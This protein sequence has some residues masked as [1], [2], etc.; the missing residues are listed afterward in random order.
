MPPKLR[1]DGVGTTSTTDDANS[2]AGDDNDSETSNATAGQ[3]VQQLLEF[4]KEQEAERNRMMRELMDTK[5]KTNESPIPRTLL[6]DRSK[7]VQVFNGEGDERHAEEWLDTFNELSL[8]CKW[9]DD[10]KLTLVQAK[11]VGPAS[12]W[13]R[14]KVKDCPTWELFELN[15]RKMFAPT[16]DP[17]NKFDEMRRRVQGKDE[18]ILA[19][20]MDKMHLCKRCGL[21]DIQSKEQILL[22]VIDRTT[23]Q[24]LMPKQYACLEDLLRDLRRSDGL[25]R[26]RR[27]HFGGSKQASTSDSKTAKATTSQQK[28]AHQKGGMWAPA[29]D[30]QGR[31]KC[32][33]CNE[34]ANHL[35]ADC[36]K[37]KRTKFCTKCMQSGHGKRD[38]KSKPQDAHPRR[39]DTL[40]VGDI[41]KYTKNV[42]INGSVDATS[43][44]DQG[45]AVTIMTASTAVRSGCVVHPATEDDAL[46]GLG[47]KKTVP[48][49][50]TR[51]TLEIDGI[52]A[53][54]EI[55]VVSDDVICHDVLVGRT[56][57][58]LDNVVMIK[59]KDQMRLIDSS[60]EGPFKNFTLDDGEFKCTLRSTETVTVPPKTVQF[61]NV[62]SGDTDET[63]LIMFPHYGDGLSCLLEVRKGHTMVPVINDSHEPLII[64]KD[65]SFG[66]AEPVEICAQ[67]ETIPTDDDR[68]MQQS[69]PKESTCDVLSVG[70]VNA[71]QPITQE[72][73]KVGSNVT[74]SQKQELVNMLN[75]YRRCF[76][77]NLNEL[78]KTDV[79]SMTIEEVE[80][81]KPPYSRPYRATHDEREQLRRIV[82]ELKAAG[83][84]RDSTSPYASPCLLVKK[85]N[86][87]FRKVV[88][89]RRL[90]QQTTKDRF[91][92]PIIDD[93][94]DRLSGSEYFTTLDLASGYMQVPIEEESVPK[95]AF[96]TP[97]G[98]YEYLYMSFGL[99][100]APSVFQ[101]LINKALG[102]LRFQTAVCY[103]DDILVPSKTCEEGMSA[104]RRV[105]EALKKANL[106][107]KLQKCDFLMEEVSFLGF[108]ITKN[109][110]QPGEIKLEAIRQ[111]PRPK[112]VHEVRRFLGLISYFRRFIPQH[113]LKA[114]P[115][116]ELTKKNA[117][118]IWGER[119]EKAF[120]TLKEELT[121]AP[122]LALYDRNAE[123]ELHTD[124]CRDGL[125]AI[126]LQPGSDGRWN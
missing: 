67:G 93:Q 41:G 82:D 83:I 121:S 33:N 28:P 89:Y 49:G 85:K 98:H 100:N 96:I 51:A 57:L 62:Q 18:S 116:T 111:Y 52:S 44:I 114:A 95:T 63:N 106:T 38:C 107:L 15:F 14:T 78:G 87:E 2:K 119:Q 70:N 40:C 1:S 92:L 47:Q 103:L 84:V 68:L 74:Q 94:L 101:R 86:G 102:P 34:Y 16:S 124:A 125:A 108:R 91:P 8:H 64:K 72:N 39:Q 112:N 45:S 30:K 97:D 9:N 117:P 75:E 42:R 36:P 22:G 12:Q 6:P 50:K 81:S 76:A 20:F 13:Y 32:F 29:R 90:N 66:R 55:Y 23:Y 109:G 59:A 24:M 26:E 53:D 65:F 126:L 35:A 123:T 5:A 27:D 115:L 56:F 122:I 73:V 79:T 77:M 104:L 48:L 4:I 17:V 118:F 11:L 71:A 113:A 99:C 25:E 110:I 60:K 21:S 46:Y 10:A 61:V 120:E 80:G 69:T 31:V 54:V 19:Y 58:D 37:E 88:D 105:L 3:Y 43:F 7:E